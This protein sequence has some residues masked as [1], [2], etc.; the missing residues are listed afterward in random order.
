QVLRNILFDNNAPNG[1]IAYI[2]NSAPLQD[3]WKRIFIAF[4]GSGE[5][6]E[7]NLERGTWKKA[8]HTDADINPGKVHL[9]KYSAVILYQE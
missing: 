3:K 9:K 1:T 2:I 8:I 6:K 7:I 4:N 5:E